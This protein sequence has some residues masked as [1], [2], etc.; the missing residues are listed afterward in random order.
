MRRMSRSLQASAAGLALANKAVL[1]FARKADLATD[2]AISRS[3]I[4]KFFS[5]KPIARENFHQ[6]CDRLGI[7]WRV[8][9]EEDCDFQTTSGDIGD[10]L[11]LEPELR[12][13]EPQDIE[14]L[15]QQVR[16]QGQASVQAQY[17]MIRVLDMTQPLS[18]LE[19]YTS[20][21]VLEKISGRRRSK[22]EHLIKS[23]RDSPERLI[24]NHH[25]ERERVS[26]LKLAHQ[27]NKLIVLGRPG[28]GKTTFL[29]FLV[30]QCSL[31]NF[32][33]NCVPIYI[34]L[35]DFAEEP[36]QPSLTDYINDQI[37]DYGVELR[38]VA[39]RLLQHGRLLM[40]LDGLDEVKEQDR[41]RV[42]QDIQ[43][44][45]L[46]FPD[47][48]MV[49]AC[50]LA[51][52]DY[53]FE[54]FTEV[55]VAAF[56]DEQIR[57]FVSHWF[58]ARLRNQRIAASTA[59]CCL[60]KLF[61][62][63]NL[64]IR[65]LATNPLLLTLLCLV[66]EERDDFPRNRC[67]LYQEGLDILLKQWDAGRNIN[68]TSID[69]QFTLAHRITLLS[70]LAWATFEQGNYFF[71]QDEVD[72]HIQTY[73]ST[74]PALT[75]CADSGAILQSIE[76]QHGL[77]VQRSRQIYS[78]CHLTFH[79]YL[80]AHEIVF[81]NRSERPDRL[82]RLVEHITEPGWR[83]VFLLVNGM[84]HHS[85]EL[86]RLMQD[87]LRQLVVCDP[88]L[89]QFLSWLEYK[90]VRVS[91]NIDPV[92]VRAFY[93][94]LE[95]GRSFQHSHRLLDLARALQPELMR[96]LTSELS[97]DL[98]LD[99][100]L[101]LMQYVGAV[102]D[103]KMTF[104][105]VINRAI[106]RADSLSMTGL[107]T[108]LEQL[109]TAIPKEVNFETWWEQCGEPWCE[110]LRAIL[111]SERDIGHQWRFEPLM[112]YYNACCLFVD[113]L[114]SRELSTPRLETTHRAHEN[115]TKDLIKLID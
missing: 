70:R 47:N 28:V 42:V 12:S 103:P 110:Q 4:Q 34:S 79:E 109:K 2:L 16:Q 8:V 84:L 9:A 56:D 21:K 26:A 1:Q 55:E 31:G 43:R 20:T 93:F 45:A 11:D 61:L 85:D 36:G 107:A 6:I 82:K 41:S 40:L 115:Y 39:E 49:M 66:F 53:V 87:R 90:S 59:Q 30:L 73:L 19:V 106:A 96:S 72:Q 74:Q 94:D 64:P 81:G 23:T 37:E 44:L 67:D 10:D 15:V 48:W 57:H 25:M 113:C 91:T 63:V 33:S 17:G 24:L 51:S 100:I 3:T 102:E 83:E 77:L 95:M 58:A 88:Q 105:R 101:A 111:I 22:L 13:T 78:F 97:L 52:Q 98:A 18:L 65:E 114:N 75:M 62:S 35:K 99:R 29:K 46:R 76:A 69:P 54:Q 5:G 86:L 104:I 7:D 80:A 14:S 92:V 112:Q 71:T 89:Q 50:R 60:E 27:V 68:R 32:Q 38:Q 108:S